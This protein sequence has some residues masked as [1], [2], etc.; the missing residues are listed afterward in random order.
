MSLPRVSWLMSRRPA[1]TVV[2]KS[3]D[4]LR[5]NFACGGLVRRRVTAAEEEADLRRSPLP[6]ENNMPQPTPAPTRSAF[7]FPDH[8]RARGRK[9]LAAA[10]KEREK[11]VEVEVAVGARG[12]EAARLPSPCPTRWRRPRWQRQ[13]QDRHR[14]SA[15]LTSS[16]RTSLNTWT[17]RRWRGWRPTS[18]PSPTLQGILRH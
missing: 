17:S 6:C 10:P 15:P 12:D 16:A 3:P 2:P 8:G 7:S 5:Q 1:E 4:A 11:E 14:V 13:R 18:L 9:R